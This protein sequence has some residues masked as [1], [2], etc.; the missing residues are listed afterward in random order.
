MNTNIFEWINNNVLYKK[1][2]NNEFILKMNRNEFEL[3]NKNVFT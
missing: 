2:T 3:N 1:T